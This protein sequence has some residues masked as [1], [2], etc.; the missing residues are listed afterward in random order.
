MGYVV[1][2]DVISSLT[3]PPT[4]VVTDSFDFLYRQIEVVD[5]PISNRIRASRQNREGQLW[6]PLQGG[7][8]K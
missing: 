6:P 8:K 1:V 4:E 2:P 5:Y 7:Y 3:T